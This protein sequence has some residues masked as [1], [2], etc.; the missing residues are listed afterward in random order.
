V[1]ASLVPTARFAQ[2]VGAAVLYP[3]IAIS[4]LFFPVSALPVSL[5]TLAWMLPTTHAVV[6]LEGTWDGV[7]W[8]ALWPHVGALVL[9]FAAGSA[10]AARV[11][12]WE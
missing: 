4:G 7:A 6:V 8:R 12:R 1:I 10:L 11:F 9:I 2:P 3:M 5:Q